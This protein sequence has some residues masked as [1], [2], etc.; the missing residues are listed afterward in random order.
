M[1]LQ[2]HTELDEESLMWCVFHTETDKCVATF[3]DRD[4]AVTY[5]DDLNDVR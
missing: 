4:E 1:E 5:C 3:C 2:Y